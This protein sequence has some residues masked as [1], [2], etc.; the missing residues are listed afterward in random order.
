MISALR[1]ACSQHFGELFSTKMTGFIIS[2]P[3]ERVDTWLDAFLDYGNWWWVGRREWNSNNSTFHDCF[4]VQLMFI[5]TPALSSQMWCCSEASSGR[6]G[7]QLWRD[8]RGFCHFLVPVCVCESSPPGREMMCQIESRLLTAQEDSSEAPVPIEMVF[9]IIILVQVE[10]IT[11][12][13]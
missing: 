4:T 10:A 13:S 1:D 5:C 6:E 12:W 2:V 11:R 8:V 9:S 3:A 7:R